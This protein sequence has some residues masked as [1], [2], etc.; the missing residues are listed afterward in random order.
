M[1]NMEERQGEIRKDMENM[2]ENKVENMINKDPLPPFFFEKKG[3]VLFF[4]PCVCNKKEGIWC[5]YS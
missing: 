4:L 5:I 3:V 2:E 1:E